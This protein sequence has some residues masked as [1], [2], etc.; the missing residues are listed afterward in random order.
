M[1]QH[2]TVAP[3][4]VVTVLFAREKK[5]HLDAYHRQYVWRRQREKMNM[6]D[7]KIVLHIQFA[8]VNVGYMK[9]VV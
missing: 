9:F 6:D 7:L 3:S 2:P 5:T 8:R 4:I 1:I